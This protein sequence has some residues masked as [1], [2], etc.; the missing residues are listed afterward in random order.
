MGHVVEWGVVA[1]RHATLPTLTT[2]ALLGEGALRDGPKRQRVISIKMQRFTRTKLFAEA[3]Q[4]PYSFLTKD[5]TILGGPRS[6]SSC[7]W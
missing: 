2:A 4:F 6:R 1:G 7:A 3:K 5:S